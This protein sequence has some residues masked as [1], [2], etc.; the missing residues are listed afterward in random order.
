MLLYPLQG[1]A[2]LNNYVTEIMSSTKS[3]ISPLYAS[4][5]ITAIMI[6]ANLLYL[7]IVDRF[8]RRTLYMWST[9]ATAIGLTLFAL[10]LYLLT[11][12]RAFD[13]V[14]VVCLSYISFVNSLGMYPIPWLIIVET[15][16]NKVWTPSRVT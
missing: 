3:N 13:W 10:H 12:N 11:D 1:T 6:G 2:I 8:G 14:P 9:L 4:T 7:N 5:I 15:M 16:P